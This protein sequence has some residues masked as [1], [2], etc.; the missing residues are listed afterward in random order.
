MPTEGAQH[1]VALMTTWLGAPDGP[2]DEFLDC[3]RRLIDEHPTL[4]RLG[5]AVELIMGLTQLGGGLLTVLEESTGSPA[6]ETLQEFGLLYA[7]S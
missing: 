1:A 2:S 7:R 6:A 5:A 3:L 4:D